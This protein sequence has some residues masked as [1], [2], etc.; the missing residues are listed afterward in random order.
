MILLSV[1]PVSVAL[2]ID[3]MSLAVSIGLA[4]IKRR[5]FF[6]LT[7]I[8][9]VFHIIMPLS[10]LSL[11]TYLGRLIGPLAGVIGALV[12]ISIGLST[13]WGG[14]QELRGKATKPQTRDKWLLNLN[15]PVSLVLLAASVSLDALTVG[16]GLGAVRVDL[17][18][19]VLTMGVVAGL[20]TAA[21]LI[22][23]RRLNHAFGEKAEL[24]SGI[25]LVIVG[26]KL[27]LG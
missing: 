19:T 21:G 2:G 1:L 6:L 15:N 20:M 9:T 27:L 7:G 8:I 4:G 23:G 3:A 11:G 13:I 10:G 16:F 14:I 5:E 26:I 17:F 18:T 25:I 12:L 22:S 24:V